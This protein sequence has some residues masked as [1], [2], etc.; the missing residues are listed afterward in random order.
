M[1]APVVSAT[2]AVLAHVPGLARHGSKPRRELADDPELEQRFLAALRTFEQ[3]VAYP[4]HQ[5]YLGALHPRDLPE[6]PWI[7]AAPNGADRFAGAGELMPEQEFVGLMA[8]VDDFDL[9]ALDPE[10]AEDAANALGRHPLAERF[11]LERLGSA[12]GDVEAATEEGAIPLH[13]GSERLVGAMRGAHEADEALSAAV[14]L[15]NLAGKASATLAMARLLDDNG[16]ESGSIDFVLGAGEEAIGDRYQRGGGNMAKAVAEATGL[17]EASGADVK[18]FCAAPVPAIVIAGSLVA[19]GV[20]DRVAVVAGGSL[21]KLGMKFEGHLAND[22][23]VLE[24]VLGGAA[25]LVEADDGRSP[26]IRLDSVA[27]HR[28]AA[29]SSNPKIMEAL[30]VEP[31]DRLGI[32]M[33]EVDDYATELHNPEITEPQRSGDVPKRNYKT[34]A[35]VAVR[36]GRL[37]REDVDAFVAERGMPGFAP[38]QGHIASALCY[39]PHAHARLSSGDAQRVQLIAK[40]G[41]FLGRMSELSDGMSVL[42]EAN[43]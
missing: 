35:A 3:A 37:A 21:P 22:L 24:D 31:L 30:C 25:L 18:N 38:T 15:E 4:P 14:L 26:R 16:I 1:S 5:A 9:I 34:I 2:S 7:A 29:G 42:L 40:G 23:P 39:L 10:H 6:R 32:G 12:A 19:S 17:S 28:V 41:L 33:L 8:A 43:S 11:D 20:F 36:S 27:R 13:L